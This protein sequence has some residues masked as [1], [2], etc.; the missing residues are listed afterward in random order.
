MKFN[1]N[2]V[3]VIGAGNMGAGIASVIAGAGLPVLLLDIVPNE[4]GEDDIKKGLTKESYAFRNKFAIG[5]LELASHKKFGVMYDPDHKHL[6]EV[7]NLEDDFNK[8]AE[9][10]WIIE[11]VVERL[12]VKKDLF[13]RIA[14]VVKPTAIVT[15][16]TSGISINKMV[17]DLPLEF[18]QRFLGTHFFNPPRHMRLFEMIPCTD[19]LPEVYDFIASVGSHR[20]GKGIVN[21]KDT[22]N[23]VGNRIGVHSSALTMHLMLKHD[24]TIEEVD[25]LT[26]PIMGRP[27]TATFKTADLVG[28]D[29]LFHTCKTAIEN[30]KTG[31]DLSTFELPEFAQTMLANKQLGNKTKGGFYKKA[32]D[33]KKKVTLVLDYKT[34]EYVPASKPEIAALAAAK[35]GKTFA[36]K[37]NILIDGDDKYSK[38]AWECLKGSL[39]YSANRVPEIADDFKDIDK[40][41]SYGFNWEFGPFALWNVLGYEKILNKIKADGDEIPAWIL[42]RNK[43]FYE[44]A[45]LDTRLSAIYTP[46]K[47]TQDYDL[48]DMGDGVLII[49]FKTKQNSMNDNILEGVIS[50]VDYLNENP[51]YVGLVIGNNSANFC[52]GVDIMGM[53]EARVKNDQEALV[54]K[55][56]YFQTVARKL[57]Y[58]GKPV[59][60]AIRGMVLGG[61]VELTLH[62][63]AVVAHVETYM[64]LIE[65]SVG[66]LPA[67]GG[68]KELLY[69]F[70]EKVSD[71]DVKDRVPMVKKAWENISFCKV[72][73]NAY[74]AKRLGFLKESDLIVMNIDEVLEAGKAKVL[75]LHNEGYKQAINRPV[76]VTG[77]SGKAALDYIA[78]NMKEGNFMSEHDTVIAHAIADVLT[79]GDVAAGTILTEDDILALEKKNIQMLVNSEK[80]FERIE[81]FAKTGRKIRN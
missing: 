72:S 23:F 5:G 63:S 70:T 75:S 46:I 77:V 4:L 27:K 65:A 42:E 7:G 18:R 64:G 33:G 40:A 81:S 9:C 16:N 60:S 34:G 48:L 24:L 71:F 78:F 31:E 21:A 36:E 73:K 66:I 50:S 6:V 52:A 56:D 1:L 2:K 53:Y 35:K 37:L 22:P 17:E 26:G 13:A 28:L 69:R 32:L 38:F 45:D 29:I 79:G 3:A 74:D 39:L 59:V 51:E 49:D 30:I 61:G 55:V 8:L 14:K 76:K 58:S 10:D 15:S 44:D 47:T 67:G 41:L 62:S 68:T 57:K 25:M 11:V 19:T 43:P 20:L 54:K 12:D 80:T